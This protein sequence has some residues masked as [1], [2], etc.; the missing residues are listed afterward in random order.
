MTKI[1]RIF[2]T[3]LLLIVVL[4]GASTGFAQT[5][6]VPSN[7]IVVSTNTSL[8]GVFG[9]GGKVTPG[10]VV[11]MTDAV[12]PN[13][14]IFTFTGPSG[15]TLG[16][17]ITWSL[18]GDLSNTATAGTLSGIVGNY[19]GQTQPAN[20]TSATIISYNKLF[21]PSEG[22]S[23]TSPLNNPS[24]ARSK[25]KVTVNYTTNL[26]L[27]PGVFIGGSVSFEIFKKFTA[28]PISNVP[29]IVG[30]DCVEAL[31]QCTFSVDQIVSD[32]AND[33]IG[34]DKYYWNGIPSGATNLYYS[35]D[36]SSV[37]FTPATSAVINLSCCIGKA[38]STPWSD[39]ANNGPL[40]TTSYTYSTCVSKTVGS[41]PSQ[42]T[43]TGNNPNGLCVPTGTGLN[44]F[45]ISY[46]S[47]NI[48][49]W[50]MANT[51]WTI[52]AQ[53]TTLP[54]QSVTINTNGF[55]NPGVLTL[56]VSNGTCTPLTFQYQINRKYG[57]G[58]VIS[59]IIRDDICLLAGSSNNMFSISTSAS[60][61][62]T[63]WSVSPSG[64]GVTLAPS[65]PN[66]T[67]AVNVASTASV[68]LYTLTASSTACGGDITYQFRVKP[69]VPTITGNACV[70]KGA[71]GTTANQI[72]TCLA[73]TGATYTWA[74]P[75]GWQPTTG[76][77]T[78]NSNTIT[79]TPSSATA[80]LNGNA[81]VTANGI[82]GCNN[83]SANFAINYASV[84][85]TDVVASCFSVGVAGT[86]SVT[87]SNPV[88]SG[89]YYGILTATG[90]SV[91]SITGTA[92]SLTIASV[93]T[94][95]G[96][97]LNSTVSGTLSFSTSA[98]VAGTYDL[99]IYHNSGCGD[100]VFSTTQITVSGN[101]TTIGT[102]YGNPTDNYFAF[103]PGILS[104]Q[105]QWYAN[106][107]AVA[108][109]AGTGPSLSLSGTVQPPAG[110]Q[111]CVEVFP[112]GSTCKTRVCV[113]QG[114][115]SR[116][117]NTI[118]KGESIDGVSIYPNPNSGT[119]TINIVDFKKEA[120][121]TLYDYSGK[122]IKDF[123]LTKGEN[124]IENKGLLQGNYFI[125][126]TIDEKTDVKQ[127]II[128]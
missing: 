107:V 69:N 126:I 83:I 3:Q 27:C 127:I 115:H 71:T 25:G 29:K 85:P 128:K 121:A 21:R 120:I 103:T 82:V 88:G 40:R 100:A 78:T 93:L 31:K 43:F 108:G 34:F 118:I 101:N 105:Y 97:L 110:A 80:V 12:T 91:N 68:G 35:A 14:G 37:T 81:T 32:N 45:T 44:P 104:P 59:S 38:N 9:A 1:Y 77:F 117:A 10:G 16:P 90:S 73:S 86:G 46:T 95:V 122:K 42:P 2:K 75:A 5:V 84:A 55:N 50:T 28:T 8:G 94:N 51:G 102:S 56:T 15:V 72:Y 30:P 96:V 79:V 19:N 99:K 70:I 66:S 52:G 64:T 4:F 112:L 92:V 67:V 36:N 98:L 23:T 48:C 6:T 20:G 26:T 113:A 61:N 87:Y 62:P 33:N 57:E 76:T 7:C 63:T 124:K 123:N 17:V 60:A 89:S 53:T 24:W 47:T 39:T 13:G 54:N 125:A 22:V 106:G 119:F 74:F 114:I 11:T 111:V 41:A 18:S 116:T 109:S 58:V 49:T 65:T